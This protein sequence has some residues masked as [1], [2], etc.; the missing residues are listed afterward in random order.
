[1]KRLEFVARRLAFKDGLDPDATAFDARIELWRNQHVALLPNSV[2]QMP[3][4][5]FYVDRAFEAIEASE[6]FL[7][8]DAEQTKR[9]KNYANGDMLGFGWGLDKNWAGVPTSQLPIYNEF[10]LTEEKPT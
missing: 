8:F 2:H 6:T 5:M 10:P 9:A 1:M 4:W 3:A 7:A